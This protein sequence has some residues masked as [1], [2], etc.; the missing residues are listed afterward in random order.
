MEPALTQDSS[1]R[2]IEK[3]GERSGV[4]LRGRVVHVL[5]RVVLLYR[6]VLGAVDLQHGWIQVLL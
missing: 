5:G 3:D 2:P 1:F 4:V 6:P